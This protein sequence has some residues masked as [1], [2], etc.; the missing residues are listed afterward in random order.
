MALDGIA[1]DPHAIPLNEDGRI[2]NV[3]IVLGEE[4]EALDD[5]DALYH[6]TLPGR[7]RTARPLSEDQQNRGDDRNGQ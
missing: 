1:V 5:T 6:A 3:Q 7:S 4:E 2:H